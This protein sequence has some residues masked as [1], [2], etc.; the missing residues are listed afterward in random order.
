MSADN[1]IYIGK[2][3][4]TTNIQDGFEF[5]VIHAQAID[6]ISL[7]PDGYEQKE[8][9]FKG[10]NPRSIVEYFGQTEILDELSAQQKAFK[11]EQ[12]ILNDDYCPILEYGIS[13][14]TFTQPFDF[15]QAHKADI[16][17]KWDKFEQEV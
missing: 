13:T 5:R 12:E 17:Y 8:Q 11:M 9:E 14:I 2:F 10:E 7:F 4:K 16:K 1:G 15:Y 6:N 3:P